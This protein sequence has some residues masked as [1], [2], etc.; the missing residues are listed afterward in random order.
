MSKTP[1]RVRLAAGADGG[2]GAGKEVEGRGGE[3]S[4]GADLG[5]THQSARTRSKHSANA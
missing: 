3:E 5:S 1:A 4:V 2:G